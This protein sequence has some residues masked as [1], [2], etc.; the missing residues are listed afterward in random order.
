MVAAVVKFE[1]VNPQCPKERTSALDEAE[2][3]ASQQLVGIIDVLLGLTLVEGAL[4]FRSMFTE[5]SSANVPAVVAMV[6]VYY[7]AV[8]SFVDWHLAMETYRY[9]VLTEDRRGS[10]LRRVF[11]DFMIMAS[12]SFL[13]LRT[14]VLIGKP[15]S[16]LT[17]VAITYPAVYLAYLVW[18]EL[19][20]KA[21]PIMWCPGQFRRRLLV[22]TFLVS[23]VLLVAYQAGYQ[24]GW[25][26]TDQK[27]FNTVFLSGELVLMLWFR[28]K[29][30]SQQTI[31][32]DEVPRQPT[33]ERSGCTQGGGPGRC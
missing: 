6:L 23:G 14:H 33:R 12:Y 16:D 2:L 22:V 7:T 20:K 27:D 24:Q 21:Y 11:L 4:G 15:G 28:H 25:L 31:L 17:A 13:I 10:E 32:K 29:N 30:W 5:G 8:R 1:L 19:V 3:R 9:R 18:G 26:G